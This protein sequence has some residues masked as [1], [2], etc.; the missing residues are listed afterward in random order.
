MTAVEQKPLALPHTL[1]ITE[2]SPIATLQETEDLQE[3][4]N[5]RLDDEWANQM[6][7]QEFSTFDAAIGSEDAAGL[8]NAMTPL[9]SLGI[10][11]PRV[12]ELTKAVERVAAQEGL[13][14]EE[15]LA[16]DFSVRIRSGVSQEGGVTRVEFETVIPKTTAEFVEAR[17]REVIS[18]MHRGDDV[19][20]HSTQHTLGI[21]QSGALRPKAA[22]EPGR[23]RLAT[24][25]S[26][27]QQK[28]LQGAQPTSADLPHL[29]HA[30]ASGERVSGDHSLMV[31]FS[32][33]DITGERTPRVN[34]SAFIFFRADIVKQSPVGLPENE[35]ISSG[36]YGTLE[37]T[38]STGPDS[39]LQDMANELTTNSTGSDVCFAASRDD[40][41]AAGQY[42]YPVEESVMAFENPGSATKF[43]AELMNTA[44]AKGNLS[45]QLPAFL[46]PP[47]SD[48]IGSWLSTVV[49]Y[50][51]SGQEIPVEASELGKALHSVL[52][53][54]IHSTSNEQPVDRLSLLALSTET[55]MKRFVGEALPQY[56][57]WASDNIV[58]LRGNH[59]DPNSNTLD[60][61]R[62][63]NLLTSKASTKGVS[64]KLTLNAGTK[65]LGYNQAQL[66]AQ[67]PY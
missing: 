60:A 9:V 41:E 23:V 22:H 62:L 2:G 7:E 53:A 34:G 18:T 40:V 50:A 45:D 32:S 12:E 28:T 52:T 16:R 20:A 65:S 21:L 54:E 4:S 48:N 24:G 57:S 49:D 1:P 26:D 31:H 35:A 13:T 5:I 11:T 10:D 61:A 17:Q 3:S 37:A 67:V 47:S 58:V 51:L 55:I 19:L 44:Q 43:L 56:G 33:T 63:S 38:L 30:A 15:L 42:G 39:A 59:S 25:D 14:K 36:S 46:I 29:K 27:I 66:N 64:Q 8:H 6:A